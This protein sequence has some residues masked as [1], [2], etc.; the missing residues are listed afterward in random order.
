ML[1]RRA[2]LSVL[3]T[4]LAFAA[5]ENTFRV[6][7]SVHPGVVPFEIVVH[8]ESIEDNGFSAIRAIE[9]TSA[10]KPVQSI[11]YPDDKPIVPVISAA[12][13]LTDVNCDGF[14]DLLVQSEVNVHGDA[15]YHLYL[16]EPSKGIFVLYP[17]FSKLPF[18]RVDCQS[19][20]VKTHLNSG[21]AGCIY[22]DADY[23]WSG[24]RLIP[25][26]IESQM[27]S[28]EAMET[29]TRTVERWHAGKRTI[30]KKTVSAENCHA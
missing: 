27:S 25:I 12:V 18:Q 8:A 16:Y 4:P 17:G 3:I 28:D 19:K 5:G 24:K 1:A 9:I 15:W 13:S 6:R 29:F 20:I 10:G 23:R 2:L 26:R 22:E 11:R 7:G 30:T 14:K 21:A